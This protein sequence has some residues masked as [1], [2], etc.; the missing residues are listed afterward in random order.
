MPVLVKDQFTVKG[1]TKVVKQ[2]IY[3]TEV[4]KDSPAEKA[5]LLKGDKISSISVPACS[6]TQAAQTCTKQGVLTLGGAD[7]TKDALIEFNTSHAGETAT[8]VYEREGKSNETTATYRTKDVVEESKKGDK[9]LGYLGVNR[10][11][12][13]TIRRSTWSAPLVGLGISK[14]LGWAT[15]KGLGTAIGGAGKALKGLVTGNKVERQE[16]QTKASEQLGGTVL[17]VA[18]LKDLSNV[19]FSFV[20]FFVAILSLG[21]AVM[22][23]LPIPALDGGRLFVTLLFR[24]FKKPLTKEREEKIHGTGFA[25]LMLLFV[26]ITILDIKRITGK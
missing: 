19:G 13:Y 8:I 17:I 12:D 7:L 20:L 3:V 23:I 6:N 2:A 14:D 22:N 16:G 24:L 4:V 11:V 26:V 10:P 18:I 5:G 15:V 9:P 21:L 25:V 1:D